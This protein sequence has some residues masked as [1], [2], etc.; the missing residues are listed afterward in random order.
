VKVS[1]HQN[2]LSNVMIKKK[3]STYQD[4]YR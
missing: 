3:M 4:C 2:L 1:I